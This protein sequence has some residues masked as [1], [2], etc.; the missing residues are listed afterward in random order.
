VKESWAEVV[1]NNDAGLGDRRG[2][3]AARALGVRSRAMPE[4]RRGRLAGR[5]PLVAV[6]RGDLK[7]HRLRGSDFG[8]DI[9]MCMHAPL[10]PAP[11]EKS[12]RFLHEASD[13]F[14]HSDL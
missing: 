9:V 6:P 2:T 8:W 13:F 1:A 5:W 11:S 12:I 3:Q 14:T 4:C 7:Q 10:L